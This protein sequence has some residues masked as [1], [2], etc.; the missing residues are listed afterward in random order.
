MTEREKLMAKA[1]G[2]DHLD[3]WVASAQWKPQLNKIQHRNVESGPAV[4]ETPFHLP[5]SRLEHRFWDHRQPLDGRTEGKPRASQRF[6]HAILPFG[7]RESEL[8]M[9]PT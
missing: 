5:H 2:K 1:L 7:H 6:P 4:E 3:M 8:G 9:A